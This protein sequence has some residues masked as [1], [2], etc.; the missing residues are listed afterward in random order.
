MILTFLEFIASQFMSE[1][2]LPA[3]LMSLARSIWLAI[4]E[5]LPGS[6][7]IQHIWYSQRKSVAYQINF[8]QT[9]C[10]GVLAVLV[11]EKSDAEGS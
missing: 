2:I 3:L 10:E 6:S 7:G 1:V 8:Q 11:P 9:N 4:F 5:L